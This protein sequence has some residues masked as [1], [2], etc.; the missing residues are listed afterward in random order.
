MSMTVSLN[1]V[2]PSILLCQHAEQFADRQAAL[3]DTP[4]GG[5]CQFRSP[6]LCHLV[7]RS[8]QTKLSRGAKSASWKRS[9]LSI[10]FPAA[11]PRVCLKP[12][13]ARQT[14]MAT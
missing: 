2:L 13:T 12:A 10:R 1:A 9:V 14:E 5:E 8:T 6:E 11:V 7:E 3:A 4:V